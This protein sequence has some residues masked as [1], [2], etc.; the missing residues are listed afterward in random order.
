MSKGIHLIYLGII[1]V[2]SYLLWQQP[3]TVPEGKPQA[4]DPIPLSSDQHQADAT[5][6]ESEVERLITATTKAEA[7]DERDNAEVAGIESNEGSE[8]QRQRARTSLHFTDEEMAELLKKTI[9]VDKVKELLHTEAVDQDWAYAMQENLKLLYDQ[10]D[11]LQ[12]AT[13]NHIECYTT[14]CEIQ[15]TNTDAPIDFMSSFHHHM[16]QAPWYSGN[17]QSVMMSD[18]ETQIQTFYL[19]RTD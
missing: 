16:V 6:H 10:N 7:M 2:L 11:T 4:A 17:Y 15:F 8:Q 13:L 18:S 12:R 14:V 5:P 19:V 9:N 1:A 3:A